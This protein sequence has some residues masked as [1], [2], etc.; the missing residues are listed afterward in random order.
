VDMQSV[1]C[2]VK[3]LYKIKEIEIKLFL[4]KLNLKVEG[5]TKMILL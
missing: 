3:L 2:T 4:S 5:T 1:L